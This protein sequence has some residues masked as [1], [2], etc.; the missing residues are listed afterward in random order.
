MVSPLGF[1]ARNRTR[2]VWPV[3][4][5]IFSNVG[6]FH[7][8]ISLFEYPCVLTNYFVVFE[9][10]RLHTCDP[11]SILSSIVPSSVFQNLMVLSADPPP[12][13]STPWLWGFHARPLTAAQCWL[14]LLT[15]IVECVFHIMSLLSLPP[16]ASDC[17]SND[18]FNPQTSCVWP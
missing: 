7:T 14:N 2:L 12:D 8:T 13:A 5:A 9:K 6:Y 18:H 1:I 15:G 4:V 3:S 17:P 11:V 16:D 10:I